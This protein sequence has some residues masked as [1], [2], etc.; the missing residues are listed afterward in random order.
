MATTHTTPVGVRVPVI[1]ASQRYAVEQPYLVRLTHWLSA[2][3]LVILTM[4][5]LESFAAFPTFVDKVPQRDLFDP[6]AVARLGGW[7][8]GAMQWHLA[9]AWPF[10][11]AG[12]V[13]AAYQAVSG[14]W[15]QTILLPSEV[16]G[17]WPMVRYYLRLGRKPDQREPYNP[18]QKL[19]Y[20][21]TL[22]SAAAAVA[23]TGVMLYKPV[24]LGWLVEL[25]GGFGAVRLMHFAAM[26]GLLAFIPGHLLMVALH[27]WNNLRSMLIGLKRDPEYPRGERPGAGARH[28]G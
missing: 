1:D 3:V 10:V 18:L 9:F 13:Y 19:A 16:C 24:Q 15:R 20:T 22:G 23:G 2:G 17:V 7:L 4:S 28:F 21:V 8:G 5:G 6:P 11:A 25:C 12:V 27:G 26:C 14:R